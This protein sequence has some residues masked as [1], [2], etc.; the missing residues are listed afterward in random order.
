MNL[1]IVGTGY[2]GLVTG[3]CFAEMGN[4]VICV[5]VDKEKVQRL[6][7]GEVPIYEPHLD[8]Y[9]E[10]NIKANRLTFTTELEEA[11]A[12]SQVIF[13][14]LPTPPGEDGSA[15]LSYVLG[16][17]EQLGKMIK[18]YKIIV[19]KSTV[20][21]GTAEKVRKAVAKNA[22]VE[23]DVVSN[24]EFLREGFAV[25]DFMKPDRVVIGTSSE[26]AKQILN[27]LY[28]P[29][30][31]QG[32]PVYFMDERSSELT[33]YAANA[34]LATKITF[35][36]EIANLCERVGAN[37]DMVRMGIGSDS[38]IG[39]R[40]LFAGI[41]YGGSCFPK[42]VQAL[43]KTSS[44]YDYDFKV[45]HS[46]MDV[47]REQKTALIP[48]IL[49]YFD[50]DLKG[51]KIAVWGLAFK[52]DT[53]DIREAPAL[54]NIEALLAHGAKVT[55]FD[56]EAMNNVKKLMDNRITFEETQ[57]DALKDADA[58]LIATEWTVFRTPDFNKMTELMKN[59]VI[60]DGR[61]LYDPEKMKSLGYYY[62]SIG[63]LVADPSPQ[64]KKNTPKNINA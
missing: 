64:T 37:V 32:N 10:R 19:N 34:F 36:N 53:D 58:L 61:N 50:N 21:V 12:N 59:K 49:N 35:M 33:K 13:L 24:P 27:D 2:V 1:A 43:S 9:F 57:Y 60:F 62:A 20:P 42:D 3:T 38:R 52:P 16:V 44:E 48:R 18:E 23:F 56:P 11:V 45:L 14:A 7:N 51:K 15:D 47:N 28:T 25:E 39:K 63:R 41:G 26:K 4:T 22:K 40:F 31:R 54:Y 30:V 55:A 17:A 29:F 46:V 6:K 5:D 8:V